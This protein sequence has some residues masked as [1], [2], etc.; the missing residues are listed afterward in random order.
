MAR[1]PIASRNA[2]PNTTLEW[3]SE[4]QKPADVDRVP[5]PDQLAGGVVDHGDVVGVECVPHP[6]QV[7]RHAQS[8][9]EDARRAQRDVL[10]R[11]PEHQY[12]PA[13]DMERQ[14]D[15]AHR[16]DR[17]PI[18][19]IETVRDYGFR[20]RCDTHTLDPMSSSDHLSR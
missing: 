2:S 7:G 11:H 19:S 9:A 4:N 16:G 12:A 20:L 5:S 10:W 3:P 17:R 1:T 6:E 14:D 15:A 18:G 8:D 13:E